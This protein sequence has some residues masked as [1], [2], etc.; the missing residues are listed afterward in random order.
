MKNKR[1][2][3]VFIMAIFLAVAA[4]GVSPGIAWAGSDDTIVVVRIRDLAFVPPEVTIRP[5]STVRWIN[6]D[7]IAHDVT[8]GSVVSGRR[9][10]QVKKSRQPDGKFHSGA[11]GQGKTYEHTFD[12]A[13]DYPY[14]CTIHPSMT[15]VVHVVK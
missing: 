14:F 8:S 3:F 13:G 15:G 4:T 10:R 1:I 7:P 9:A 5:G 11:Y 12:D 2:F 6:E